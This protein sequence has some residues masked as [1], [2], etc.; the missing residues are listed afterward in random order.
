MSQFDVTIISATA[1]LTAKMRAP[2]TERP[3]P[4]ISDPYAAMLV[5]QS[6]LDF[7]S[8]ELAQVTGQRLSE[9]IV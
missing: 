1:V 5:E 8:L 3:A 2:E 6:G 9:N 7:S 4:L